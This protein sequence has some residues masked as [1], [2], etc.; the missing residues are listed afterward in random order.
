MTQQLGYTCGDI[1]RCD[2]EG[3]AT[4][5]CSFTIDGE[6]WEDMWMTCLL[7]DKRVHIWGYKTQPANCRNIAIYRHKT[8]VPTG[9][10]NF[11]RVVNVLPPQEY[12]EP[13]K[14]K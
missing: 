5:E 9:C 10:V 7:C 12:R 6:G 8:D 4:G 13:G 11:N 14:P 3:S 2:M 1:G